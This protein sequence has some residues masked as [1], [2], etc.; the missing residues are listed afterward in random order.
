MNIR[1]LLD[2]WWL[3]VDLVW[4]F[5]TYWTSGDSWWTDACL[6]ANDD[7][8]GGVRHYVWMLSVSAAQCRGKM[9]DLLCVYLLQASIVLRTCWSFVLLFSRLLLVCCSGLMCFV[10]DWFWVCYEASF[11]ADV[12]GS[13]LDNPKERSFLC[14]AKIAVWWENNFSTEI[15]CRRYRRWIMFPGSQLYIFVK[16]LLG[17]SCSAFCKHVL[18]GLFG[19]CCVCVCYCLCVSVIGSLRQETTPCT[20]KIPGFHFSPGSAETL[21][22]WGRKE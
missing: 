4:I 16:S 14:F 18:S 1:D 7:G 6:T 13:Q 10:R 9:R 8:G 19:L 3:T 11:L 15:C 2:H 5:M 17:N 20:R 21:A 22:R 12:V